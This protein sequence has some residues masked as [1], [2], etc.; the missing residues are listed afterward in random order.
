MP[1]KH[2][3]ASYRNR[4]GIH[5]VCDGDILDTT[6]GNLEQQAAARVR[7]LRDSGKKA[8]Y[9]QQDGGRYFRVFV[10]ARL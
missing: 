6:Y 5:Y 4:D 8:F 3:M 1:V 9:E 7:E 10:E 2:Q